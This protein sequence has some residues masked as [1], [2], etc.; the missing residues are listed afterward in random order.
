MM[1]REP[2]E[3]NPLEK[4]IGFQLVNKFPA[5]YETRRFI[6]A[7]TAAVFNVMYH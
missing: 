1:A 5:C 2:N 6:T 4:L 7:F 3:Q